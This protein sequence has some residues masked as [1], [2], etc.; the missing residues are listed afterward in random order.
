MRRKEGESYKAQNAFVPMNYCGVGH[1]RSSYII[2]TANFISTQ[3]CVSLL[4]LHS[5][6]NLDVYYS[7]P[8]SSQS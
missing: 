4:F 2:T 3:V 8:V 6:S 1:K 7:N 5:G